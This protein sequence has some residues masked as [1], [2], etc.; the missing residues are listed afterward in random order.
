MEKKEL[1]YKIF[2]S[3]KEITFKKHL[4]NPFLYSSSLTAK[5]QLFLVSAN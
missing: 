4:A 5:A 2:K 3:V 1:E